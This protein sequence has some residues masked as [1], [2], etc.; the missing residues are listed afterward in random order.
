MASPSAVI[1]EAQTDFGL[2]LL[3]QT[4]S[5][6][7]ASTVLSPLSVAI[8]LS[9]VYAGARHETEAELGQLLGKGQEKEKI[10][11]Y[12]GSLIEMICASNKNYTLETANRVFV[13][14]GFPLLDAYK[15]ILNDHYQGQ[16]QSVDFAQAQAAAKT[17]NQFVE[18]ATHD[19]IHNL[20]DASSLDELTRLVL[21]N[22]VYFK[23]SWAS[24]FDEKRTQSK[25][26]YVA[27]G[28]EKKVEMMQNTDSFIYHENNDVQVLGL[29][30]E[31]EEVFMFV[32]LPKERYGLENVLTNLTGKTLLKYLQKRNKRD[33]TVSLPKFKLESTHD[34]TSILK[35]AG[36]EHSFATS[37]NFK[38][39]SDSGSL[40]ISEVIQ[41]AFI[42][43]NEEGTEAAAATGIQV[44]LLSAHIPPEFIADHPFLYVLTTNKGD[45]LF[46]GILSA[47]S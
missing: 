24:K 42:E 8:A 33:V 5:N 45:V 34:L 10:H 40:Q 14:D 44:R 37:A 30:Y 6:S 15:K 35:N 13:K 20:I 11:E 43:T 21:I 19:K 3:R 23:G 38:G 31:N 32:V 12:F 29:P 7:K 27:E 22:A 39:I 47:D 2:N 36:L 16:F 18:E 4:V 17:I 46:N 28:N 25:P 26:F 41:K 9:M 1:L